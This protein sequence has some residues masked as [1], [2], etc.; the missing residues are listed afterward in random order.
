MDK[1]NRTEPFI[2]LIPRPFALKPSPKGYRYGQHK[3]ISPEETIQRT[4]SSL[5]GIEENLLEDVSRLD[6]LDRLGIPAYTC[7]VNPEIKRA[8]GLADTF[9]KGITPEQAKASAFMELVERYSALS[10]LDN[11]CHFLIARYDNIDNHAPPPWIFLAPFE[12]YRDK[13][14]ILNDICTSPLSWTWSYSLTQKNWA[15]FPLRWFS[16][17][18]GTTGFAAGNTL[19]E[20]ILQALCE[21]VERH[22]ISMVVMDKVPTP[23]IN[24]DSIDHPITQEL[25]SKF[26]QAGILLFIK[27]FSLG[28]EIP[29]VEVLAF[30]PKAAVTT[31]RIYNAAGTHMDR[32]MALIRALTEIAQH[33]CQIIKRETIQKKPGGPTY[34]FPRF[35]DLD[36]A[37]YLTDNSSIISFDDLPNASTEDFGSEIEFAVSALSRVGMEVFVTDVTHP[38]LRVPAV[39]V[40]IPGAKLNRPGAKK[41]PYFVLARSYMAMDQYPEAIRLFKKA[42][43]LEPAEKNN[44]A[45]L[46]RMGLCYRRAGLYHEAARLFQQALEIKPELSLS[47]SFIKDLSEIMQHL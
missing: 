37:R 30:D 4:L 11:A 18:Y 22:A 5:G 1:I 12:K 15:L 39:I 27:D 34:C 13:P 23:S 40:T 31:V 8:M 3:A 36:Q 35:R 20:A 42:F 24:L 17:I 2:N 6:P 19:E 32:N 28:L 43:D 16:F 44:L 38:S 46:C 29:T 26:R 45:M 10:F 41:N 14:D 9:G 25:I 33:R 7:A 47:P 21:V